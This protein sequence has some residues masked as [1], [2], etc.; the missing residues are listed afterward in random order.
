MSATAT[1]AD[2]MAEIAA[3]AQHLGVRD[4]CNLLGCWEEQIDDQWWIAV[5]GQRHPV[6]CSHGPEV[7]PF[8]AY[9]EFNG[10]PAGIV[11]ALGEGEF[12]AGDAVNPETFAAAVQARIAATG[13]QEAGL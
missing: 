11:N 6:R 1:T 13:Q 7:G 2:P 12:A 10:W 9:L 8:E 3:L 4:I 5:N